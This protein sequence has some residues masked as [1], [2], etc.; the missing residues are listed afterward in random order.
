M[1]WHL[2]KLP[3]FLKLNN[4]PLSV[5][6]TL[7]SSI[8]PPMDTWLL[9]VEN[10]SALNMG[11]QISQDPAFSPFG[12]VPRSGTAG[13]YGSVISNFLRYHRRVFHNGYYILRSHTVRK[14]SNFL[15]CLFTLL[16]WFF[17]FFLMVAILMGM[18]WYLIG[19][20]ISIF[21]MVSNVK[22]LFMCLMCICIFSFKR[23]LFKSFSSF[24]FCL[25][26]PHLQRM[27][28]P[29]LEVKSEL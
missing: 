21:L 27:D 17:F 5:Y 14:G 15:T 16:F 29:R 18:R 6:I 1:L 3:S 9:T 23:C 4:I 25:L 22:H 26:G 28:V 19:G 13:S 2:L 7:C 24:F 11:V 8:P 20:S 10:N 12:Y